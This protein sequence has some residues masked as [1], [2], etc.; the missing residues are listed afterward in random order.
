MCIVVDDDDDNHDEDH[1]R[2]FC[3]LAIFGKAL[4]EKTKNQPSC[5]QWPG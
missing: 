5:W 4:E 2:F 1:H 3:D